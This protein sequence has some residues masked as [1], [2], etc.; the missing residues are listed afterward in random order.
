M[1]M[2]PVASYVE[3]DQRQF[4]FSWGLDHLSTVGFLLHKWSFVGAM[5]MGAAAF[6]LVYALLRRD[7]DESP[8]GLAIVAAIATGIGGTFFMRNVVATVE[9]FIQGVF[10]P[11]APLLLGIAG[12]V[13][14]AVVW[15]R[16][17]RRRRDHRDE[18]IRLLERELEQAR[19]QDLLPPP[20]RVNLIGHRR[21]EE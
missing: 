20:R 8:A 19:G 4:Y 12:M 5:G 6:L 3:A 17:P 10:M 16:W 13:A 15:A 1:K 9:M 2:Y 21:R 14:V 11:F 7:Y 18:R